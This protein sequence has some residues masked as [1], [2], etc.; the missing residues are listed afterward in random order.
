[1]NYW[2]NINQ[3]KRIKNKRKSKYGE[4]NSKKPPCK[5]Y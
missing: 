4:F 2:N 1:M 3:I 5:K